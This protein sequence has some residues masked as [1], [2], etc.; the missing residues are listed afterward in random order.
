MR[1]THCACGEKLVQ[2]K[3]SKRTRC[4]ECHADYWSA[5]YKRYQRAWYL[6][7]KAQRGNA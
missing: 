1:P 5:Y 3:T 7:R 4:A 6:K 2:P